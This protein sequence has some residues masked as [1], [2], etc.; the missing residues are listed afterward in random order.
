MSRIGKKPV[1]IPAGVKVSVKD[2]VVTAE[3]K[4]KLTLALPKLVDVEITDIEQI[5][6]T[7][8]NFTF[9]YTA[10]DKKEKDYVEEYVKGI[11]GKIN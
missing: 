2:G 10:F 6:D 4:E 7:M 9:E 11:G 1:A 5:S 8:S 3:G